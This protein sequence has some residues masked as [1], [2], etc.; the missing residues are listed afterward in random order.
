MHGEPT[1][2]MVVGGGRKVLEGLRLGRRDPKVSTGEEGAFCD[3][4]PF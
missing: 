2:E 3:C 1:E 4:D